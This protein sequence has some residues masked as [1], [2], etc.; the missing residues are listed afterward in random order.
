MA[1][2]HEGG[3]QRS[4]H[5]SG[6]MLATI[7]DLPLSINLEVAALVVILCSISSLLSGMHL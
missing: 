5:L 1:G 6:W 2:F 4:G 3:M 7:D